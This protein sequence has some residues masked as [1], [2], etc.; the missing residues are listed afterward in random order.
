MYKEK[1]RL[2]TG[3]LLPRLFPSK[4]RPRVANARKIAQSCGHF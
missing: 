1:G 3:I 4:H 2:K